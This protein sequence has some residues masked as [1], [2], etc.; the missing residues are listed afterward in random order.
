MDNL[1]KQF[2]ILA[3]KKAAIVMD[4][5]ANGFKDP[6]ARQDTK[7]LAYAITWAVQQIESSCDMLEAL[8]EIGVAIEGG[9]PQAISDAWLS[10]GVPAISKTRGE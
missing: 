6:Q 7:D 3:L 1:E 8:E 9:D 10:L 2:R 4:A 5:L